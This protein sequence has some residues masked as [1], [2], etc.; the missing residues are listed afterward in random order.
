LELRE[1][2]TRDRVS[3]DCNIVEPKEKADGGVFG[4]SKDSDNFDS[5]KGEPHVESIIMDEMIDINRYKFNGLI[6]NYMWSTCP[7]LPKF[8]I[9]FGEPIERQEIST[10]FEV[11]KD[12][13]PRHGAS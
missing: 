13:D 8:H 10:E 2:S 4:G 5:K 9:T 12:K 11:N 6:Q 1:L 3:F 7:V